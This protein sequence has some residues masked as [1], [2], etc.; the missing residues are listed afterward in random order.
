MVTIQHIEVNNEPIPFKFGS[1]WYSKV[2]ERTKIKSLEELI[3]KMTA[4]DTKFIAEML[5]CAHESASNDLAKKVESKEINYFFN[6]I[7]T[8]GLVAIITKISEA[9]VE[10]TGVSSMD[11]DQLNDIVRKATKKK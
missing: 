3:Q 8:V 7:D 9:I 6:I 5:L 10:L 1:I 4:M 2:V 11:E